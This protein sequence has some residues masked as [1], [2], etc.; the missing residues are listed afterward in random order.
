VKTSEL[1]DGAADVI[2]R[3]GWVQ[4]D[5]W[6][7]ETDSEGAP[8]DPR[9]CPVC[10]RGAIAVAAGRHPMWKIQ[11][12]RQAAC[13]DL[14]GA[15]RA[16]WEAIDVAEMALVQYIGGTNP[17]GVENWADDEARTL[18]QILFA[19]RAA[20]RAEREAGR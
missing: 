8:L 16:D 11:N 17:E 20:A 2:E 7:N 5:Y 14:V 13:G 6:N 18:P 3:K 19:L 1:L 9:D 10:P 15:E 4:K 12:D